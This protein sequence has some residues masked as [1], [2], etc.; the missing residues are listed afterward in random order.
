MTS[1][2]RYFRLFPDCHL[3]RGPARASIYFLTKKKKYQLSKSESEIFDALSGQ[4]DV[5]SVV[6][7]YGDEARKLLSQLIKEGL[8]TYFDKPVVSEPYF[9][10]SPVELRGVFEQAPVVQSLHL[11]ITNA[12]DAECGF[13]GDDQLLPAQGCNSCVRWSHDS[14]PRAA[15]AD[16]DKLVE[17][18]RD[19]DVRHIVIAGGN[20]LMEADRLF[21]LA[22]SLRKSK[23]GIGITVATNGGG[24]DKKLGE[25]VKASKL[26]MSFSVFGTTPEEYGAVTGSPEGYTKLQSALAVCR[27]LGIKYSINVVL[28]PATRETAQALHAFAASLEGHDE[29]SFTEL[30]PKQNNLV[31]I[32]SRPTGRSKM[33]G[34]DMAEYFRRRKSNFCLNGRIA[35]ALDGSVLPCPAWPKPVTSIA[36]GRGILPAFRVFEP[37]SI[38]GYWEATKTKIP[39]CKSCEN[40][41]ACADCSILEWETHRD[42]A[43]LNRYCDYD[44][45]TGVW[46]GGESTE[47]NKEKYESVRTEDSRMIRRRVP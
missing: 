32:S 3:V 13:C 42:A 23:P 19:L 15:Q 30:L 7:T 44:P 31:K 1:R 6:A 21:A 46:Q 9:P 14:G 25:Q 38:I 10:Q 11:Q 41:Y 26:E 2:V 5:D 8:G 29:V 24:L 22:A 37:D 17:E 47:Q 18:L 27:E 40:R 20:P 28:S 16:I 43:E 39:G 12:C 34:V 35:V 33:D 4:R 36:S 45:Q